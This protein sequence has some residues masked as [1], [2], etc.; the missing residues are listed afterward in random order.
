[1]MTQ[2]WPKILHV[3]FALKQFKSLSHS[4][5]ESWSTLLTVNNSMMTP[6]WP[7]SVHVGFALKQFESFS[8]SEIESWSAL[9]TVNN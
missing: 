7:K 9:L 5:I 6:K 1:M 8:H 4:E 3:G 2:K